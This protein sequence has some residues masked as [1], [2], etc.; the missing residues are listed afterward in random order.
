MISMACL[1]TFVNG[2]CPLEE[3]MLLQLPLIVTNSYSNLMLIMVPCK[4]AWMAI[5]VISGQLSQ[6]FLGDIKS[7]V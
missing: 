4:K 5:V 6:I 3:F 1:D 7:M 2:S